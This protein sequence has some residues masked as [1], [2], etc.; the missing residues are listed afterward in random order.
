MSLLDQ[1]THTVTVF[2]GCQ[3][4][5]GDGNPVTKA[6]P[7]GFPAKAVVQPISSTEASEL[8]A[9]TGEV[10]R[11]RFARGDEPEL[12]PGSQIEWLCRRWSVVG[13]PLH[14]TGSLAT[15]HNSYRIKRT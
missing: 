4:V 14:H 12:G 8:G 11:L 6:S 13:Y 9:E 15:R 10:Y 7:N 3:T 1:G 2:P 5:D